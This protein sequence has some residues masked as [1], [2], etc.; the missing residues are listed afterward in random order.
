V[1]AFDPPKRSKAEG[2]AEGDD[3]D[4]DDDIVD[5][6]ADDVAALSEG[7]V[8]EVDEMSD[9]EKEVLE[10]EVEPLRRVLKKVSIMNR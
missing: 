10:G 2:E 6:E 9:F 7:W 3:V 4:D 1:H 5:D 8:D